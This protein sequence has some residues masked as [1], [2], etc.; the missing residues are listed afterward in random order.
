VQHRRTL[1]Q[2]GFGA[3]DHGQRF[4]VN[5]DCRQGRDGLGV[6]LRDHGCHPFTDIADAIRGERG[7]STRNAIGM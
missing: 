7:L 1:F 6:G 2:G 3:D 5:L 4:I